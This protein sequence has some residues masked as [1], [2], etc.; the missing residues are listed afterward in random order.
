MRRYLPL[1]LFFLVIST[2]LFSQNLP[3]R[4]PVKETP[5][6]MS[7]RAG[8]FIDVNAPQYAESS[9]TIEKM[10]KDVLIS[11]GTNTCLTPN[12]TN[13]KI[14]P[15]H[16]ASEANRA[17]GYFHKATTNFPFKDGLILSTG[18]ARRAGNAFEG[19]LN[20]VNGGGSDADL[21]QVIGV[22]ENRLNDAVLLEFDFVPTTSQIKFNYLIASEEYTG[23]F[24]CSFAD[25]FA[26]LLKPTS[27]GPY[28]NMAV[29]PGG[30]GLVSITNIHPAVPGSCGAVNEQ[31]FG[32]Y[33]TAK[34]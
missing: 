12:V 7:G 32:G 14:T 13:V 16:A 3:P 15:N 9:Y 20:D 33:N 6:N 23:S 25:A 10:V 31:Y 34:R 21:A 17:W 4:K 27:G 24:P 1:C 18:F 22:V 8:V 28:V 2:F 29:L 30:A 26:I 11:S 19:G 5:S